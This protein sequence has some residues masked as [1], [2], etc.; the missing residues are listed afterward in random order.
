MSHRSAKVIWQ[1]NFQ[2]IL[3]AQSRGPFFFRLEV[4]RSLA[5]GNEFYEG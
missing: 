5:L 4:D 2:V 3:G 1:S